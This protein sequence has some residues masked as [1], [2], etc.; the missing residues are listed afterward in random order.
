MAVSPEAETDVIVEVERVEISKVL[1]SG[2]MLSFADNGIE[3]QLIEF[4]EDETKQAGNDN[5]FNFVDLNFKSGSNDIDEKSMK[6]VENIAAILKE[7]PNVKVKIGG[8][9]DNTGTA[10]GNLKLSDERATNVKNALV[11]LGIGADRLTSE[12]FGQEHPV[13]S[14]D[15][16]EGKKQNRRIAVSVREK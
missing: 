13:A 6:E 9:T 11:N 3:D 14:N 10:E 4:I 16:E 5:W 2:L 1:P 7:Y 8:Y 15:T 12:G